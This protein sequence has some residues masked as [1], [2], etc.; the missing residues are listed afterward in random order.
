MKI[1]E[2]Q[3]ETYD[4]E[5]YSLFPESKVIYETIIEKIDK[6][7]RILEIGC[8][9]GQL[10]IQLAKKD[11]DVVA[12]D[13][14][15][16]M[17]TFAMGNAKKNGVEI[18]FIEGDFTS[19]KTFQEIVELGPFD[20]I[21]STFVLSEFTPLKQQLF[22]K[23]TNQ[24]LK[25]T[26]TLFISADTFPSSLLK[27]IGSSVK[28]FINSQISIYRNIPLTNPVKDFEKLLSNFFSYELLFEKS[29]IKFFQCKL[30]KHHKYEVKSQAELKSILGRFKRLKV[31]WCILNGIFTRRQIQPGL[32]R[33]GTPTKKS[34]LLITGNYY[35][36]VHSVF[37][38]LI[39]QQINGYLLVIDSKG[40]NI[41]CAAGGGHFTHSQVIDALRLFDAH[42]VVDHKNL[43]LPQL[44]AT[45]VDHKELKKFGWKPEF[46]PVYIEDLNYY[47]RNNSKQI[48]QATV[49]F[50]F[51]YR[52]VLGIQHT[53]FLIIVFFL[54]MGLITG[55][56]AFLR[57]AGGVFWFNV[58]LQLALVGCG[59]SMLFAWGFPLFNFT[60]SYFKKGLIFGIINAIIT[61]LY[62][63]FQNMKFH[64][65]TVAF[66]I[67][68][69]L[70]VTIAI[71]LD[72][73]GSTPYTNHLDVESDLVLF[74]LPAI[75]LSLV[76]LII[77]IVFPPIAYL[78]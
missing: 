2:K 66:W 58:I 8:G 69:V 50:D 3:P 62:L 41:W 27:R 46:G 52:T 35:W 72:F 16:D 49:R 53:F 18:N 77:P 23:Q 65:G 34:P 71:T 68:L 28:R 55:L 67:I 47:I 51:P 21:V 6:K 29:A 54:P 43:I 1:L 32:Y 9:T 60:S 25:E 56:F 38:S 63:A 78:F 40:I 5:F 74:S 19:F 30:E 31:A 57:V 7:G 10:A 12:V 70:L 4:E 45:G 24:L 22:I 73:A 59:I 26:G 17:I 39:K 11:L 44:S 36:T 15:S 37:N 20:F 76:V 13:I 61:F 14:S 75:I 64:A 42:L 48:P 33:I